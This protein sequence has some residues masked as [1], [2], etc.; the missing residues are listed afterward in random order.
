MFFIMILSSVS[1]IF[2]G[3]LDPCWDVSVQCS[4][5]P[6]R[7]GS[8]L[9][10]FRTWFLLEWGWLVGQRIQPILDKK[11]LVWCLWP[12]WWSHDVGNTFH[13][14]GPFWG[15][16][17]NNQGWIPLKGTDLWTKW[18]QILDEKCLDCPH[19]G[20]AM[21]DFDNFLLVCL[22]KLLNKQLRGWWFQTSYVT[23]L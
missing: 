18:Q 14:I 12:S 4:Y 21:H 20:P 13:I 7:W 22:N 5:V 15:E 6:K 17:T 3:Y 19:K 9:Q 16:S 2:P 23:P 11:M 8:R 10:S 1:F